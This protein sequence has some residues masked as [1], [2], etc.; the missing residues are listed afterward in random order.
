MAKQEKQ[1][2]KEKD[3]KPEANAAE[4]TIVQP[5]PPMRQTETL[6]MLVIE[7]N[8]TRAEVRAWTMGAQETLNILNEV[9]QMVRQ[10]VANSPPL[11]PAPMPAPP[12]AEA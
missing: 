4:P 7:T 5:L 12:A 9:A 3:E 2:V 1:P 6:R 8:G 11:R 10:A